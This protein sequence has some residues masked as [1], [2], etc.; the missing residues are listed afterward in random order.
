MSISKESNSDLS[1]FENHEWLGQFWF[2]DSELKFAGVLR[3]RPSTGVEIQYLVLPHE[4]FPETQYLHGVL[5][6][7]KSCTLF[8]K[9]SISEFS[10]FATSSGTHNFK[11]CVI[12][13]HITP[14]TYFKEFYI[15]ISSMQDFFHIRK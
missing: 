3:Y 4:N 12:G 15:N 6:N 5:D 9:F 14:N 11:C 10:S 7:G 8:G 13:A 2:P 1:L